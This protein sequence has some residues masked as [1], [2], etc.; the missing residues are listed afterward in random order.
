MAATTSDARDSGETADGPGNGPRLVPP[1]DRALLEEC[2]RG[3]P[4]AWAAFVER[5]AGLL[6]FVVDRTA[7]QRRQPLARAD[8]DDL[9]A[10][11]LLEII[12]RDAAVLRSFAGRSSLATYLTVVARRVSVRGLSRLAEARGMHG[13]ADG[14]RAANIPAAEAHPT[15]DRERLED[16]LGRLPAGEAQLVRLHHLEGRSYGEISRLTGMPLNSIGPALSR[17]RQKLKDVG[18]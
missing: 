5:F 7:S 17:A 14:G 1:E 9:L 2:L 10:D 15:A 16:L 6:A 8:R 11:I 12:H 18:G 13:I 3:D 4:A